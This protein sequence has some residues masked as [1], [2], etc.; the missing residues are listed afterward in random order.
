M[1]K[2]AMTPPPANRVKTAM[3]TAGGT[4]MGGWRMRC[5]RIITKPG[6]N[7]LP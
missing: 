4:F 7:P 6:L 5:R 3:G 2:S 1:T